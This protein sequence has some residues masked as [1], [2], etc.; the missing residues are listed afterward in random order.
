MKQYIPAAI[1]S[2]I[3]LPVS[4]WIIYKCFL[5][6][7][8]EWW[9]VAAFIVVGIVMVAVNLKFAQKLIGWFTV[10]FGLNPIV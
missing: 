7:Q 3:C 5:T 9:Y 4:V 2:V 10:K 1:T 8:G 6:I